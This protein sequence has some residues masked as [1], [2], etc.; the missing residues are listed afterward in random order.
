MTVSNL[1]AIY[2]KVHSFPCLNL[3]QNN[4]VYVYIASSIKNIVKL[5][6]NEM[7]FVRKNEGPITNY[8][9]KN[10]DY[11]IYLVS[12][13][14]KGFGISA[15]FIGLG[16]DEIKKHM[17]PRYFPEHTPI[18]FTNLS[19]AYEFINDK[20]KACPVNDGYATISFKMP[21]YNTVY[22]KIGKSFKGSHN[23]EGEW[24]MEVEYSKSTD[25]LLKKNTLSSVP[26]GTKYIISIRKQYPI[27]NTKSIE[28]DV[29]PD[30][31][32]R[33]ARIYRRSPFYMLS[34]WRQV[35]EIHMDS[36]KVSSISNNETLV[37]PPV[38]ASSLTSI[39]NYVK[40][41]SAGWEISDGKSRIKFEIPSLASMSRRMN[42]RR[43]WMQRATDMHEGDMYRIEI[44][45]RYP[46]PT[47]FKR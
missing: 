28:K 42:A 6:H 33:I 37:L 36:N 18:A 44:K 45:K 22:K 32:N 38:I 20:S 31:L 3:F 25:L 2:K 47:V 35:H 10:K 43:V 23:N 14:R 17:H 11:P 8:Q 29:S 7:F 34:L 24:N 4:D 26:E 5:F 15:K 41:L 12:V 21:S 46:K 16:S 1:E 19:K 39:H 9:G 13:L 40:N 30:N 27:L